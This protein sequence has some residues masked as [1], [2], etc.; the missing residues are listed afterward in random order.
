[1][2]INFCIIINISC[3]SQEPQFGLL[4]ITWNTVDRITEIRLFL[5]DP[6]KIKVAVL[7]VWSLPLQKTE[8]IRVKLPKYCV[9]SPPLLEQ[10]LITN[11][12]QWLGTWISVSA[13]I[14]V[15][16]LTL[17]L[18]N[19]SYRSLILLKPQCPFP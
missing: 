18:P 17:L 9:F 8:T 7:T 3:S 13:G 1:M 12:A 5:G 4:A 16:S 6:F 11:M 19:W 2:F 15:E 14:R 10:I